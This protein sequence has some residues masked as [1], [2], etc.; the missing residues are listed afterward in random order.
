MR[1]ETRTGNRVAKL[2][3]KDGQKVQA[4]NNQICDSATFDYTMEVG[5]F[6]LSDCGDWKVCAVVA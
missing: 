4:P 1:G 6:T 2:K 5:P 3:F